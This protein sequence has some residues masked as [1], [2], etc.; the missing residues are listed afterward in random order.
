MKT[1]DRKDFLKSLGL[2]GI[3]TVAAPI[4]MNCRSDDEEVEDASTANS[5]TTGCSVTN[6]ETEGPY[7]TKSPSSLVQT[8]IVG[9]RTGIALTLDITV[10]NV[11]KSCAAL[12]GAIVDIWHCD[13]D[14]NYSQYG[15]YPS[16]H[17]LRGRQT[18]GADGKVY[19][20]TI[21]PGWY[22]GRSTHIH[23]HVYNSSGQSLL[24]SQIAFSEDSGSAVVLVNATSGYRGMSCY[25]YLSSD[26]VF[27]DGYA[28]ELAVITGNVSSGFALTHI[29]KVSA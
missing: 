17:F 4:I 9:D 27:G 20:T 29:L 16:A 26:N 10:Q 13:K 6:T 28:N 21:F 24:V 19:F 2:A 22:N 11:N 15:S 23:V 14:G 12:E 5:T 1:I 8:N 18:T 3:A 7:P 25:N